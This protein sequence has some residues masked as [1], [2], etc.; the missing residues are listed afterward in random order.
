MYDEEKT[1][2][3]DWTKDLKTELAEACSVQ[4]SDVEDVLEKY[5]QLKDFHQWLLERKANDLPMP[6]SRDDLM[7]IY[8]MERPAFLFKKDDKKKNYNRR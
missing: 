6:E 3:Q 1:L 7:N 8:R 4:V 5:R 2:E